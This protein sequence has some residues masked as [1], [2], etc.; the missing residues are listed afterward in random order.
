MRRYEIDPVIG[1]P[2][3][4]SI[5]VFNGPFW[6]GYAGYQLGLNVFVFYLSL[7]SRWRTDVRLVAAISIVAFFTH[8]VIYFAVVLAAAVFSLSER[9]LIPFGLAILP[10]MLL[11]LWYVHAN[12]TSTV[13]G[14]PVILNNVGAFM[15]YKIYTF[16]KLGPYHAFVISGVPQAG[17]LN[18]AG[19]GLGLLTN[20]TFLLALA[21]AI[22]TVV[23]WREGT[24]LIQT[25][26][27]IIGL[28][29]VFI[30]LLLSPTALGVGNP[31]E[32]LVYPGFLAL[33]TVT[34]KLARPAAA[35]RAMAV[36]RAGI[37]VATVLGFT[38]SSAGV[39]AASIVYKNGYGKLSASRGSA[40]GSVNGRTLF[41]HRMVQFNDRMME[42]EREWRTKSPPTLPLAFDTALLAPRH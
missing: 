37:L 19:T 33:S 7:S 13:G 14:E 20:L 23:T 16:M 21:L 9:R 25:P 4:L 32:R 2:L 41:A 5:F 3:L 39:V 8:G 26:E 40:V 27:V 34:F 35:N 24:K 11:A 12:S 15:A 30:A 42:T 10:S 17:R 36:A 29:L 38:L 1:F 31:S 28:T 22:S 18:L 6:S